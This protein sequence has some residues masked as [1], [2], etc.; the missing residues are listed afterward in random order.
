MRGRDAGCWR[1]EG[2]RTD[3]N[4]LAANVDGEDA[5]DRSEELWA[6]LLFAKDSDPPPPEADAEAVWSPGR[7]MRSAQSHFLGHR[8]VRISATICAEL[9]LSHPQFY[10]KFCKQKSLYTPP[11]TSALEPS[12]HFR[13]KGGRKAFSKLTNSVLP[14]IA[15]SAFSAPSVKDG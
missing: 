1:K 10:F 3:L 15:P 12:V 4:S 14:L 9:M 2:P 8:R 5:S 13:I 11:Q 7:R 6:P